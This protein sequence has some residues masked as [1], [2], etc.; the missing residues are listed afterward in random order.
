[1]TGL[2]P[3]DSVRAV[4]DHL[5]QVVPDAYKHDAHHWL[6]L[7]GRY[8]CVARKPMCPKCLIRDLCEYKEKT[9][10]EEISGHGAAQ[11]LIAQQISAVGRRKQKA[12]DNPAPKKTRRAAAL[13]ARTRRLD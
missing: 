7:H 2:A 13:S 6:I 3:G 11:G 10:P 1:R 9:R 12:P 5:L 4:E 8:V